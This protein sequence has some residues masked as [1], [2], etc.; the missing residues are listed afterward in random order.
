MTL[1]PMAR[2]PGLWDQMEASI[3]WAIVG[4]RLTG[5]N[6]KRFVFFYLQT[7]AEQL[8]NEVGRCLNIILNVIT[9]L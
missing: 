3:E 4:F 7:C 2:N 6:H 9:L 1:A 5:G 8:L